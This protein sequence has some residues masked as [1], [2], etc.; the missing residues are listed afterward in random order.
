M[1]DITHLK[2]FILINQWSIID[3]LEKK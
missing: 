1:F 3:Y 2:Y